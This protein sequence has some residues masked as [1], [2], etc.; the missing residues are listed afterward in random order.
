MSGTENK[1]R[2]SKRIARKFPILLIGSDA[3][4]KVFTE[5]TH[6]VMLSQHGAGIASKHKLLAQQKFVMVLQQQAAKREVAVRVVGEIGQQEGT[7]VYGVAFVDPNLEFWQEE[8]PEAA[9]WQERPEELVLE[10]S[11][12]KSVA[13]IANG[14]YEYDICAIHGG[15]VRYCDTCGMLQVWKHLPDGLP[16]ASNRE[17]GAEKPPSEH[18]ERR[19]HLRT[20]VK[21]F[22]CVRS[23]EFGEEIVMCLDMSQGGVSFHC[24]NSYAKGMQVRLAVPYAP[25]AKGSPALFVHGKVTYLK[26]I[27]GEE[28]FRCGVQFSLS[29]AGVES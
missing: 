21:Y 16:T 2:R 13:Q 27:P 14:D 7:H 3:E 10:C 15:L 11:G 4:G 20:R 9:P 22:G 5:E 29:E 12:C 18:A 24:R 17:T 26:E 25:E 6:T 28:V 1:V 19:A 8:L 23:Q